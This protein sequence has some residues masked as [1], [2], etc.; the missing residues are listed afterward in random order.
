MNKECCLKK[1]I[2]QLKKQNLE[3]EKRLRA[4]EIICFRNG[5][6][7]ENNSHMIKVICNVLDDIKYNRFLF[8]KK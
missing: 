8:K 1:E 5:L 6:S 4:L 2:K 7:V 3:L